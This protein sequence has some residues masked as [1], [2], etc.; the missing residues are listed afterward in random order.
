MY[1]KTLNLATQNNNNNNKYIY[2]E[3]NR[4]KKVKFKK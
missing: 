2:F 1:I 3:K 4:I